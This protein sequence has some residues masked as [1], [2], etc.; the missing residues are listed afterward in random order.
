MLRLL[1]LESRTP[2]ARDTRK[3]EDEVVGP[4]Y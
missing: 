4:Q 2:E 3:I 1:K